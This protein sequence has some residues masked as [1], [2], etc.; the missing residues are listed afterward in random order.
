MSEQS[1]TQNLE[2]RAQLFK[3]L[4]H[5]TRL[6]ILNLLLVK[7]RHT[8]EL[9]A[10]LQLQP[11]TVSHH[12]AQLNGAGLLTSTKEQYY[13]IY[14]LHEAALQHS[15]RELVTLQEPGLNT[16]VAPDAYRDKVL[17]TFFRHGRLHQ[18]PAQRK[19]RL[20]VLEKLVQAFEI[21]QPYSELEV[22]RIL[23][24]YHEDVATLRRELIVNQLM[25]RTDGI[26]R[27]VVNEPAPPG[28]D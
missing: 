9:A 13:Q 12:L 7:P 25:V 15:L 19:K 20:V 23:V 2:T 1:Y 6:L 4:G 24:E 18:I 22:N 27:R 26:Y 17:E 11:A 21:E 3:A 16:A 8:E 28:N 5:P 14:Q 10:I